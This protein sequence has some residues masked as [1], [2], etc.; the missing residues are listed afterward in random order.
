M[1]K[2]FPC[3]TFLG[4]KQLIPFCL[5]AALLAACS[6]PPPAD[7]IL[8]NGNFYTMDEARPRAEALAARNGRLVAVGSSAE[9]LK[10]RG[11]QTEVID[12][13]GATA[14]PGFIEGHAHLMGLGE[15]RRT[16][17]LTRAANYEE[18]VALVAEAAR[19]R[20]PGEWIIGRGWHQ[21]KW[22]PQPA[23]LVSGYQTHEALSAATPE[24]PVFLAHASGH[25]AFANAKAM[26]LAG[27]GPQSRSGSDGEIIRHADGRPTGIFTEHA[28]ALIEAVIPPASE[29]GLRRDLAAALEECLRNGITSF[30]D[31]GAGQAV[32]D[33]YRAAAEK[34]E[35]PLRLYVMLDGSDSALLAR[36]YRQGPYQND[37]LSVRA[38][39]YYGDGALGSRGAWL[40]ADYS[41]RSGHQGNPLMRPEALRRA[42]D[43][44]L[45]HGFQMCTHAIGDR[46]NREVL[47]AYEAA[48]RAQPEA[49]RDARFRIEHAQHLDPADIPR[50]AA[51][52]VIPAMQ[53]IHMSSDRPWAIERLGE[54]RIVDGAYVWQS[55][56]RSGAFIVNGTD[57]PVEPVSPIACFYASVTRQTL[58]GQPPGGYEPS[59]KMSREQALRSYTLD[60]ARGAFAEAQQ[61]SLQPGK[62]ADIAVL[63]Q[64]LMAVPDSAL[65]RT[66]VLMTFSGGKLRYRKP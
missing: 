19:S 26:E 56:L 17:D 45:A 30:H 36:W 44:A 49:A 1:Q 2:C 11:P 59:Q 51:L 47:D 58:A 31:A 62:W 64:D 65:L 41:D 61:G 39:K 54:Q 29:E 40:L 13:G 10:L 12:L 8:H 7:L 27:I 52:G 28:A 38:I 37:Y 4:M 9:V 66:E 23:P 43:S 21:S 48:F 32:I 20:P 6:S 60:A 22:L 33:L 14:V 25:A 3:R 42:A 16:L 18:L 57:A 53:A 46:A 35:L 15:F 34:G 24:H 50:F 63:S 5:L 55:L